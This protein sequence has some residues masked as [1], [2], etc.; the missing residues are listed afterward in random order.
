MDSKINVLIVDGH[1][2]RALASVRSL[3]DM[4]NYNVIVGSSQRLNST[5]FSRYCNRFRLY[6]NPDHDLEGFINDINR[7]LLESRIDVM[8]PMDDR[9]ASYVAKNQKSF[10]LLTEILVPEWDVFRIAQDKSLT[11]SVAE[12]LGIPTPK[13]YSIKEALE[14]EEISYP[15]IIKPTVSSASIGMSVIK[16]RQDLETSISRISK[17]FPAIVIQEMIPQGGGHY[18][19]NMI[20]DKTS[21]LVCSSVKNKIREYPLTGGPSTFFRTVDY[22]I[23]EE[24][25]ERL[26]KEI[27]WIG[28]AEV[29]FMI[30]P[31]TNEPVLMEIN[32]RMSAT[33]I[34]SIKAGVN[35]PDYIVKCAL[36]RNSEM[37]VRNKNY[38]IFCQWLIPGDLSNFIFNKKRFRDPFGY[39]IKK[40]GITCHHMTYDR[41]DLFPFFI[42]LF[43][44]MKSAFNPSKIRK[45]L[46]R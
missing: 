1:D 37:R 42:N 44:V 25:S 18:Q 35:F 40:K 5:R 12:E 13:S 19:A 29:E 41:K 28:P 32:P 43:I 36:D 23:I 6:R 16:N 9:M 39:F 30:D 2:R 14:L 26:L 8:I 22:P 34:L 11:L 20:F 27:E 46:F 7:I 17:R 21:E 33:I 15:L 24:H 45:F 4:G 31:R 38:N 3:G 10:H